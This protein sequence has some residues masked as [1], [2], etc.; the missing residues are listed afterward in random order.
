MRAE[1]GSGPPTP[2]YWASMSMVSRVSEPCGRGVC[3]E[4]WSP[5]WA[6]NARH[7]SEGWVSRN[8]PTQPRRPLWPSA[9]AG[10]RKDCLERGLWAASAA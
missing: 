7:V 4:R 6:R 9:A 10:T 5:L 3:G 1:I 8:R 2:A